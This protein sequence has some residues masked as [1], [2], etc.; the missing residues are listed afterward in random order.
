MDTQI[1][2]PKTLQE[3][4]IYFSNPDNCLSYLM[5]RRWP[6][7]VTCPTC[8][9]K[10][11]GYIASRRMFQCKTRHPKAQFSVKLGTIFE[12]SPLGLDKWL[13]AM[14]MIANNRNGISSCELHRAL[15]VTQKTAWFMLHRIRLAMQDEYNGGKLW[16]EVEVDETFIG[17]KA[18]NMHRDK[19][20]ERIRGRGP[21]GK[22]I[23][24]AVLQR[25]KKICA[26][27]VDT[28]RKPSLQALVRDNVEP[29]AALY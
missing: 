18:R 27:V 17:G 5:A 24:A 4:V 22:A 7:G 19:R 12:D 1:T 21:E 9:S 26:T 15:K 28:R 20:E 11:V 16:G 14:W 13:P 6:N 29:G 8:G 2:D 10:H 3:A 25:G 23:V